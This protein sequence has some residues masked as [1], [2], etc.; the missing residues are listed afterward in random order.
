MDSGDSTFSFGEY[1]ENPREKRGLMPDVRLVSPDGL[2]RNIAL[3]A[4][5]AIIHTDL[6]D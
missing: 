4:F 1:L 3:A 5:Y 6:A 2:V